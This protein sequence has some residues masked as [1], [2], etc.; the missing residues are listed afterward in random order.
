MCIRDRERI[1][2]FRSTAL[3]RPLVIGTDVWK[4]FGFNAVVYLCLL[5]TSSD[6]LEWMTF[7]KNHIHAAPG[8]ASSTENN[9]RLG[10][11]YL[12]NG[13]WDGEQLID[14]E[15][16]NKATTRRIHT[17]VINKESHLDNG[18]GYG[19]SHIHI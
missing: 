13:Q 9:L 18:A 11:L 10:M 15:W 12:Q 1:A 3:F 8:V 14:P 7:H 17:E 16:I 2:F 5:Y 4:E 6:K 19:L